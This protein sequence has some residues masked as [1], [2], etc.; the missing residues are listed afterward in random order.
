MTMRPT[1]PDDLPSDPRKAYL[2]GWRDRGIKS[3]RKAGK[4]TSDA[5]AESSRAN[6]AKGGRPKK[7]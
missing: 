7:T 4:A 2:R 5:K 6:G 1:V 3:A